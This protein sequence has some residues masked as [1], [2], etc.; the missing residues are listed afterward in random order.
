MTRK[1]QIEIIL[2]IVII[3]L[4][5]L[6]ILTIINGEV[7]VFLNIGAL[8]MTY[9]ILHYWQKKIKKATGEM[10]KVK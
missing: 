3:F 8:A 5:I 7:T 9:I 2:K 4:V 10:V 1:Q 6:F